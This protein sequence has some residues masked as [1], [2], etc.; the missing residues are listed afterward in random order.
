LIKTKSGK[1]FAT[2]SDDWTWWDPCVPAKLRELVDT[3]VKLVVFTNQKGFGGKPTNDLTDRI[4]KLQK[5]V[6]V[7]LLVLAALGN[8]VFQKPCVDAWKHMVKESNG[9]LVPSLADCLF[10]GDAAGR[11]ATKK[12]PVKK[13]VSDTD[14]KFAL[15]LGV[16]FQTPEEFFSGPAFAKATGRPYSM[17]FDFDPRV[18]GLGR[19]N[20]SGDTMKIVPSGNPE[21]ILLVGPP[22]AGKSSLVS[23]NFPEYVRAN[24]DTLKTRDKCVKT[25]TEALKS[26][27][28]AIVDNQNKDKA[29]RKAYL[30]VAKAAGVASRAVLLDLPKELCFHLNRYRLL[31][32]RSPE[33]RDE[34]VP[35][36]V[37]HSYFK[38]VQPPTKE[39]GFA[40]VLKISLDDFRFRGSPED[41]ALLRS[42]LC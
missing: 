14:L 11:P 12:P 15:N 26:G 32:A 30:D 38:S 37:I 6:G 28:S 19:A 8:D 16:R 23:L 40:D 17:T 13:D 2:D 5:S 10:V 39:E 24:Q 22:G 36:L 9:G 29:T 42:F 21:L 3:N 7:P 20:N 25:V 1:A 41:L 18:L 31:N 27:K 35:A 4:D 34:S 33:H